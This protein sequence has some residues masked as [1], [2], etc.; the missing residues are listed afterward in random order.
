MPEATLISVGQ[1]R[2]GPVVFFSDGLKSKL[3][4]DRHLGIRKR[5][6]PIYSR[7]P[8]VHWSQSGEDIF[9]GDLLPGKRG[10]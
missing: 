6:L 5:L 1:L 4:P 7:I 8:R 2:S 9:L 3:G 10:T